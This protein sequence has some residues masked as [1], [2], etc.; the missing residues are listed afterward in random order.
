MLNNL[1]KPGLTDTVV[2]YLQRWRDPTY[3]TEIIIKDEINQFI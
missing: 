1:A 2:Y 3:T